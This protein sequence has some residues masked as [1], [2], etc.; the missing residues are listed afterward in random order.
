MQIDFDKLFGA[1]PAEPEQGNG[2]SPQNIEISP[3]QGLLEPAERADIEKALKVLHDYKIFR[4][5]TD[6]IMQQIEQDVGKQDPLLLLLM[7]AEALDRISGRG[8]GYY[9][10]LKACID[11]AGLK[12]KPYEPTA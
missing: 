8:D 3:P 1:A 12:V 10:R 11:A 5:I 4:Q 9:K 6:G 7:A 2:S